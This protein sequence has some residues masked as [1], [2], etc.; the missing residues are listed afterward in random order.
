[1]NEPICPA[2]GDTLES[3]KTIDSYRD[4]DSAKYLCL[5]YCPTCGKEYQWREV[6]FFSHIK[7]LEECIG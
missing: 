5:G 4:E 2:C 7:D 6:Y 1:M 3:F